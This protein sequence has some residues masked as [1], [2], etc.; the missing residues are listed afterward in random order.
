VCVVSGRVVQTQAAGIVAASGYLR[1]TRP[2]DADTE[3][4]NFIPCSVVASA[5]HDFG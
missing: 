5:N 4:I 1:A 2:T 3:V